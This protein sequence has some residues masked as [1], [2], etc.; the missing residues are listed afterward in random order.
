MHS[1]VNLLYPELIK[2]KGLLVV[3]LFC[4]KKK[5]SLDIQLLFNKIYF[6]LLV[7]ALVIIKRPPQLSYFS[8]L[9]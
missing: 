1:P 6:K 2:G 8:F 5:K 4:K 9:F 3:M 7:A